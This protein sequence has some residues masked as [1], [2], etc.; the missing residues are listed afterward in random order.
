MSADKIIE[1]AN[2]LLQ[3]LLNAFGAGGTVALVIVIALLLFGYKVYTDWRK[4]KEPNQAIAAKDE[5]IQLLASENR[6]L[7]AINLKLQG[8]SEDFIDKVILK[9]IPKDPIEA[10]NMLEGER[11][12]EDNGERGDKDGS[13]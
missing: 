12:L 4:N 13:S 7:R 6:T 9:G 11:S 1:A 2:G 5:S 8:M 3:T 10:R